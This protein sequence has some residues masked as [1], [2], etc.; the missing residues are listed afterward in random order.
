ME[1]EFVQVKFKIKKM[2]K[3]KNNLKKKNQK[4]KEMGFVLVIINVL[5]IIIF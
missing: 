5:A 1:L 3:K 2:F 4:K